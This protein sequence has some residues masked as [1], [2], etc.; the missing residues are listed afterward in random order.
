M[1][2]LTA[3]DWSICFT[4]CQTLLAPETSRIRWYITET[5]LSICNLPQIWE[6]AGC[7]CH[8]ILISNSSCVQFT[9]RKSD[10]TAVFIFLNL[11]VT[12]IGEIFKSMHWE[13]APIQIWS[14]LISQNP[15]KTQ[16]FHSTSKGFTPMQFIRLKNLEHFCFC[17][18]SALVFLTQ[19]N[20]ST[21]IYFTR[22]LS[23]KIIMIF[24]VPWA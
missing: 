17:Y 14:R 18:F 22:V 3:Q 13:W 8:S 1:Q 20:L 12:K 7:P 15:L 4:L 9:V 24:T 6:L 19:I 16:R 10:C 21:Q 2:V 5:K 11:L 23:R